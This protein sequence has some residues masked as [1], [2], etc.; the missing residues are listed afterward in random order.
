MKKLKEL[1]TLENLLCL[2]I[3]MCP[4]LDI[5]SFLFRNFFKTSYSPST[6]IRPIIPGICFIILF[7]KEKNKKKKILAISIYLLYSIIH[8]YFFQKLHNGSSYGNIKN[9]I[10]YIINYSLMII[11]LYLFYAIIKDKNKVKKVVFISLIIYIVS[12]Y[13]S[14]LTNT[15]SSTYLE[16]IGYKGYFESG[17]SLCTVLILSLCI[18][19]SDFNF[20]QWGKIILIIFS[21]I[22][23]VVFSGM[24]TGLFGFCIIIAV[25]IIGKFFI[26]IREKVKFNK[27]QIII[28]TFGIIFT[29]IIMFVLGSR[30][31]ERR[32]FLK[33]NELNNI[34]EETQTVRYVTG[35]ILDIYKKI[36][37][38]EISE[39]YMSEAEK[40]AIIDLCEY[41]EKHKISNVNLRNQQLIYNIFLVK[42][43]K[44]IL[45]LLFGNGYKNQTGELVMEMEVPAILCNF[46]IVG[47]GLYLGPILYMLF[48]GIYKKIKNINIDKIM[49]T[50]GCG[51]AL[52]LSSLSGYVFFNC[53][54]M[55]MAIILIIL[56]KKC[57]VRG[58]KL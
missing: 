7:F 8:L 9:E 41:A 46:G 23:L 19:L 22:Y 3:L 24:R 26:A 48:I 11:N 57:D 54:S 33:Q 25:W 44:N 13:F 51:L 15:S 45:L 21:G 5:T 39:E 55:T 17:N 58:E 36:K 37:N 34:D 12:L 31:L 47:F 49:Y 27:K 50:T 35:D 38:N 14:I 30:T 18:I 16:E 10:Q 1:C 42:E 28:I 56:L 20:K 6:I 32:K 52:F 4:L 43:Q 40:N 2:Y 53:S 29:T